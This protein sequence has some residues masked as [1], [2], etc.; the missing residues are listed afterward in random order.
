M[1]TTPWMSLEDR[2]RAWKQ[3]M[4]GSMWVRSYE[5]SDPWRLE[6]G[7]ECRA[8]GGAWVREETRGAKLD[9]GLHSVGTP[10]RCPP[11]HFSAV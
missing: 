1:C 8:R 5:A 2:S 11:A 4:H 6:V 3:I 9:R 10:S 7:G